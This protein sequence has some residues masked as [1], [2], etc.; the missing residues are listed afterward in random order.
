M[1]SVQIGIEN[2]LNSSWERK[3]AQPQLLEL[4][5]EYVVLK[6]E[7]EHAYVLTKSSKYSQFRS[8]LKS[9]LG[10]NLKKIR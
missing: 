10:R 5:E 2:V 3:H 8:V 1:T 7:V 6:V 9:G 4:P